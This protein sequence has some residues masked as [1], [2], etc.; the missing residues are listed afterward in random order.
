MTPAPAEPDTP[1]R[2][3]T[4]APQVEQ[5]APYTDED[6]RADLQAVITL[7]AG[8]YD[9]DPTTPNQSETRR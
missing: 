5:P 3:A 7:L 8:L 4:P 1:S 6:Q 2:S 9:D